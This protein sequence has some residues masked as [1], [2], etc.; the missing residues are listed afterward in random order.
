MHKN[1]TQKDLSDWKGKIEK[2]NNKEQEKEFEANIPKQQLEELA[3]RLFPNARYFKYLG[4]NMEFTTDFGIFSHQN[5]HSRT[6]EEI[7]REMVNNLS[8]ARNGVI[9][10]D[11]LISEQSEKQL[12]NISPNNDKKTSVLENTKKGLAIGFAGINALVN[13][14]HATARGTNI[15]S[16]LGEVFENKHVSHAVKQFDKTWVC[17]D[18]HSITSRFNPGKCHFCGKS[19]VPK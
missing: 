8:S 18:G 11:T 7:D 1:L 4:G 13:L 3:K 6:I 5:C 19:M 9:F 10:N 12:E 17:I 15:V 14:Q 16:A 2:E